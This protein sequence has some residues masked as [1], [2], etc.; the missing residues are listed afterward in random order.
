MTTFDDLKTG[1]QHLFLNGTGTKTGVL[2]GMVDFFV[3]NFALGITK[4]MLII[5]PIIALIAVIDFLVEF[6]RNTKRDLKSLINVFTQTLLNYAIILFLAEFWVNYLYEDMFRLITQKLPMTLIGANEPITVDRLTLVFTSPF[7]VLSNI[8]NDGSKAVF[9]AID[10][11]DMTMPEINS[12]IN[13]ATTGGIMSGIGDFFVNTYKFVGTVARGAFNIVTDMS[14]GILG[15]G[16]AMVGVVFLGFKIMKLIMTVLFSF[17]FASLSIAVSLAM[18]TF[19]FIFTSKGSVAGLDG[20]LSRLLKIILNSIA[21]YTVL[22][23]FLF[24]AMDKSMMFSPLNTAQK[25]AQVQDNTY[26]LGT[27]LINNVDTFYAIFG[28]WIFMMLFSIL[29]KAVQD[30][31]GMR[32][33]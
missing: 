33:I 18:S 26:K 3:S 28:F 21:R 14:N 8:M 25:I 2:Q 17:L 1:F 27:G 16:L 29:F 13:P 7:I 20:G 32:I 19:H 4:L 31:D 6:L 11:G 24:V 23:A 10:K 22:L 30:D 12:M 9:E 5:I 15:K